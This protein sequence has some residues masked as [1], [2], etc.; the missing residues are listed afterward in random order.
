MGKEFGHTDEFIEP[1]VAYQDTTTP[2]ISLCPRPPSLDGKRIA[3]IANWKH[4]SLPFMEASSSAAT[5]RLQLKSTVTLQPDWDITD[6]EGAK[7]IMSE[8]E[9]IA[10]KS[11]VMVTGVGD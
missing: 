7:K 3:F 6:S 11:D 9:A 1:V 10:E 2:Q 4:Q 5:H 8:V